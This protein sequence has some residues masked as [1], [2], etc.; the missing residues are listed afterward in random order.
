MK[1]I[2]PIIVAFSVIA[3]S[4]VAEGHYPADQSENSF[5]EH[6]CELLRESIEISKLAAEHARA[7]EHLFPEN[8]N[9]MAENLEMW[10]KNRV[11][12]QQTFDQNC[13]IFYTS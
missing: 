7:S 9:P 1:N 3:S 5:D 8:N 13:L 4:A 12:S 10:E 11:L 2:K 6:G